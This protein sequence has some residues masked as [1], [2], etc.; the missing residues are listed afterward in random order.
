M[1]PNSL[2]QNTTTQ[3]STFPPLAVNS[4]LGYNPHMFT[5]V[6]NFDLSYLTLDQCR[7]IYAAPRPDSPVNISREY[8]DALLA[9]YVH[10]L[11]SPVY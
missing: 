1:I 9:R 5:N 11:N 2:T 4:F 7:E 3:N 8:H 6:Y 10:L